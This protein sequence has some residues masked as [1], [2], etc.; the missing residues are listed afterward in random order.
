MSTKKSSKQA[1]KADKITKPEGASKGRK[2]KPES[3]DPQDIA[4]AFGT[5]PEQRE[6]VS[7]AN[8]QSLRNAQERLA[9]KPEVPD[10]VAVLGEQHD[11]SSKD[12]ED[13]TKPIAPADD[14]VDYVALA[15]ANGKKKVAKANSA[16]EAPAKEVAAKREDDGLA[17]MDADALRKLYAEVIGRPTG[18]TNT[19]YLI[20]KIREARKGR[21]KV[22]PRAPRP[23]RRPGVEMKV[24]PIRIETDALAAMDDLVGEGKPY[25]SRMDIFRAAIAVWADMSGHT[26]LSS[27]IVGAKADDQT[28]SHTAIA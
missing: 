23:E 20:W 4:T 8:E 15:K 24:I 3:Q 26:A 11:P 6:E 28:H 14:G 13:G 5:T 16:K 21:I 22:G 1:A 17:G 2:A 19:G 25:R 27:L 12:R 7:S 9:P 18:S 10:V